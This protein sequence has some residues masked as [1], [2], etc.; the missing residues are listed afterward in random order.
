MER[1]VFN[2]CVYLGSNSRS[3]LLNELESKNYSKVLFVIII[4]P[5][6]RINYFANL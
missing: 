3:C 5:P 1:F 6:Y 4:S 2:E